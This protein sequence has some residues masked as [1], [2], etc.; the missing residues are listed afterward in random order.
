MSEQNDENG[1]EKYSKSAPGSD[2]SDNNAQGMHDLIS[3]DSYLFN[4]EGL[5]SAMCFLKNNS[6][7]N[8]DSPGCC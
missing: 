7:C 2:Y 4:T 1:I 6:S 8:M 5:E 3:A